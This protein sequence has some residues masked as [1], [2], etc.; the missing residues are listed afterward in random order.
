MELFLINCEDGM[1][2]AAFIEA[3]NK[4][5][6]ALE[7]NISGELARPFIEFEELKAKRLKEAKSK[8]R[9]KSKEA[10]VK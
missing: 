9:K 10:S 7:V 6:A 8:A 1:T 5:G 2:P 4:G 3:V